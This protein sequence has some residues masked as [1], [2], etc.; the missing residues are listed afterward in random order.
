MRAGAVAAQIVGHITRY[1]ETGRVQAYMLF[2][3]MGLVG[4]LGYYFYL[5]HHFAAHAIR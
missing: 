1:V 4:F 3:V 5:A 2:I